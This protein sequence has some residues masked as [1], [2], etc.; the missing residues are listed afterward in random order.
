MRRR[1]RTP[2]GLHP[3][4]H[5]LVTDPSNPLQFFEGSDGGLMLSDGTLKDISSRCNSRGLAGTDL[6]RCKQLLSAVPGS[7]TSLNEGLQT[8][9]FQALS[10]NPNNS[11][12]IQGG[13]QDNGTFETTGSQSLAADDLRRRRHVGLRLDEHALPRPH[14]LRVS[15]RK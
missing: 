1:R 12:N 9:Q 8:L 5:A 15:S 4:Q 6:T 13:T 7:Y 3:D 14:V 10:V 2:Q 11:K